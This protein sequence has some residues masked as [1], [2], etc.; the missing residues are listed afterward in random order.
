[1]PAKVVLPNGNVFSGSV[2][3]GVPDGIGKLTIFL[4]GRPEFRVRGIW[5]RGALVRGSAYSYRSGVIALGTN[6]EQMVAQ[7]IR[8][9]SPVCCICL[10]PMDRQH[11]WAV[12]SCGHA[13]HRSCVA[14]F[15]VDRD[16]RGLECR[17]PL[18][19]AV[20]RGRELV[21]WCGRG[22]LELIVI[23]Q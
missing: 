5:K 18:C 22:G 20:I 19:R 14:A 10:E 11:F 9:G 2:R 16:D 8:E 3:R 15:F 23:D 21:W 7:R 12:L 13:L 17:C 1:M 6:M 4:D